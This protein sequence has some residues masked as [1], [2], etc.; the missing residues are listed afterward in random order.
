MARMARVRMFKGVLAM[1][2]KMGVLAF[3]VLLLLASF[4]IRWYSAG[5]ASERLQ[6]SDARVAA[7]LQYLSTQSASADLVRS[8]TFLQAWVSGADKG[9]RVNVAL[10]MN[11]SPWL[12]WVLFDGGG[13]AASGDVRMWSGMLFPNYLRNISVVFFVLWALAAF[14]VPHVFGVKCPDCRKSFIS[15]PL[16]EVQESTVY[17]GGFDKDGFD[18][19]EIVRRDYVCPRCGY[20]KITFY[21][22]GAHTG[23]LGASPLKRWTGVGMALNIKE[24]EW[25]DR[26]LSKYLSD[27][28]GGRGL[29]FA[30]YDDWKAFY[31]ELKASE[32][33]ERPAAHA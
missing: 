21:I 24:T 16:T 15:P 14:V 11:G 22:P 29:R 3:A 31:D 23:T 19:Q 28:E 10:E 30:T 5:G 7:A 2:R 20:R 13:S 25:Y 8:G 4:A 12:A 26:I 17:G 6:L 18:L 9:Y 33:E 32:R 27:H 1:P